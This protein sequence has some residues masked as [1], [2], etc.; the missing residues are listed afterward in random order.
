MSEDQ[1]V[2]IEL[3]LGVK[4]PPDYRAFLMRDVG[5]DVLDEVTVLTEGDQIVEAT[6]EYR[7][8]FAG[9]PPW[10]EHWVYAGDESDACPY[11]VDCLS[12][13]FMQTDKGNLKRPPL[14]D[15]GSFEQ[16][17]ERRKEAAREEDERMA[18]MPPLNW[19]DHL[20]GYARVAGI[21]LLIFVVMPAVL[22]GLNVLYHR[23][24]HGTPITWEGW[25]K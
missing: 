5:D 17:H 12:G 4:L 22:F 7:R 19:K 11:V 25:P 6:L 16:F 21:L 8:G 20:R 24:V 3:K 15:F 10:P 13:R 1:I 2:A 23:V 9:L 18:A 14:Q